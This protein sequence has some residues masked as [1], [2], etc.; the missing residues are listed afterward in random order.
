MLHE[1]GF[2]I[3]DMGRLWKFNDVFAKS[4]PELIGVANGATIPSGSCSDCGND[5]FI[6]EWD[7]I[8]DAC[9]YDIQ[10]AIDEGF[11]HIVYNTSEFANSDHESCG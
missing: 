8:C 7:R 9:E 2:D 6:L 5:D 1:L 11:K 10:I 3:S 4:G